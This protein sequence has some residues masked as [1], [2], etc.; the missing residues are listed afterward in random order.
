MC[1]PTPTGRKETADQIAK[2]NDG[3][4]IHPYDNYD[5]MAGQVLPYKNTIFPIFF[6]I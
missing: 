3:V 4:I 2:E 5:V 6:C 1:D